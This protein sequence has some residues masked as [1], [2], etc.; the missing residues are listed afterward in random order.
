[1]GNYKRKK[2]KRQV[3]CSLCTDARQGN[4]LNSGIGC[5]PSVTLD[6]KNAIQSQKEQES[7]LLGE[8]GDTCCE[9]GLCWHAEYDG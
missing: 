6:K 4:S 8:E 7:E 9:S 3:R 2:S 1:M 5:S